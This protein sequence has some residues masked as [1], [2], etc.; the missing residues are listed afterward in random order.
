M[1]L[2]RGIFRLPAYA[3]AILVIGLFLI[4]AT[5]VPEFKQT[6]IDFLNAIFG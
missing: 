4:L 2:G 5:L 1:Y 3:T 6:L